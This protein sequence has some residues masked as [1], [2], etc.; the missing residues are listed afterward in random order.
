MPFA[1]D[2][3]VSE[4]LTDLTSPEGELSK[5]QVRRTSAREDEEC[6][7]C[8]DTAAQF[9]LTESSSKEG[10]KMTLEHFLAEARTASALFR[11]KVTI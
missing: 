5:L 1:C 2:D 8:S 4:A 11:L 9:E 3:H 7:Y 10:G 6:S